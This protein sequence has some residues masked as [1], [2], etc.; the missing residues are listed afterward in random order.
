MRYA[1]LMMLG[2][3]GAGIPFTIPLL[4][5]AVLIIVGL[6]QRTTSPRRSTVLLLIGTAMPVGAFYW[7]A[8]L[9]LPVWIVLAVLIVLSEPGRRTPRV[10]T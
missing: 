10:A 6:L 9:F 8:A 4:A 1:G 5:G 2:F 3:G 7:M